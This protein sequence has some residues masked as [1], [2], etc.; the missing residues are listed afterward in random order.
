MNMV[1]IVFYSELGNQA[2]VK[3]GSKEKSKNRHI[4]IAEKWQ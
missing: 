1:K 2:D 4:F 3:I